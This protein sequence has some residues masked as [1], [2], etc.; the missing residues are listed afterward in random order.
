MF[1]RPFDAAK[2]TA[3][4]EQKW[5]ISNDGAIG[6]ITWSKDGRELYYLNE[7]RA[8]RE[9]KVLAV[10]I[11]TAPAFE[12]TAARELFRLKGPL[13]GNPGQWK[14]SPDGQRFVFAVPVE[15]SNSK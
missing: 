9:I 8:T 15:A 5:K 2:A 10:E 7:D 11:K 14:I 13:P 1:V 12:S 6:G 3:A 4:G